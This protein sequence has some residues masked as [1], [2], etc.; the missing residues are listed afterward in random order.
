MWGGWEPGDAWADCDTVMPGADGVHATVEAA[1]LDLLDGSAARRDAAAEPALDA[2]V[3]RAMAEQVGMAA[4]PAEGEGGKVLAA[5]R[6]PAMP[7]RAL[8]RGAARSVE[9]A[10]DELGR[11]LWSVR[12]ASLLLEAMEREARGGLAEDALSLGVSGGAAHAACLRFPPRQGGKLPADRG[13]CRRPGRGTLPAASSRSRRPRAMPCV[14]R[15]SSIPP[16]ARPARGTFDSGT[17][18]ERAQ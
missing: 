3:H 9:V 18:A 6:R 16:R 17:A 12:Q 5:Q 7:G 13:C 2:P 4:A 1:V 10:V 11:E 14:A 8:E 15:E